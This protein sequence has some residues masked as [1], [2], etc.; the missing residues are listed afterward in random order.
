MNEIFYTS[1]EVT[2]RLSIE[3]VQSLKCPTI[4]AVKMC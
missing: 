2:L 4:I 1:N 3:G